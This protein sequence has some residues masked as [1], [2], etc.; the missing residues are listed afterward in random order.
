MRSDE[1]IWATL[2]YET[3]ESGIVRYGKLLTLSQI[4]RLIE[5]IDDMDADNGLAAS[6]T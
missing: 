2:E 4:A 6:Q 1:K 3:D 5:D